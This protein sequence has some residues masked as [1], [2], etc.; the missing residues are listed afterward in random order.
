MGRDVKVILILNSSNYRFRKSI[1]LFYIRVSS[2]FCVQKFFWSL[3]LM[4]EMKVQY[5]HYTQ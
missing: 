3:S 5:L 1:L 2:L 4:Y